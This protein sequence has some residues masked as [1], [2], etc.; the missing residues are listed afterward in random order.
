M[1]DIHPDVQAALDMARNLRHRIADMRERI[2]GIRA[3]RPSPGGDVI[4]E[5]DAMGR[6]TDL[7]IAPG[8]TMRYTSDELVQE[9]MAAVTESTADAARQHRAI[10]DSAVTDEDGEGTHAEAVAPAAGQRA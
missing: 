3:R 8:T 10:M 6:L 4:P 7:Y 2:D 5:V 1:S 9:I